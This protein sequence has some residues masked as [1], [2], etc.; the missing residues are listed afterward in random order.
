MWRR[1][2]WKR[3]SQRHIV[4]VDCFLDCWVLVA[5]EVEQRVDGIVARTPPVGKPRVV[6]SGYVFPKAD[7]RVGLGKVQTQVVAVD[8]RYTRQNADVR[9]IGSKRFERADNIPGEFS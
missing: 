8:N 9:A 4:A 3:V 5:D 7:A 1:E 2:E 6:W